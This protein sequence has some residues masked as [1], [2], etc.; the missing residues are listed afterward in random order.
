M[1]VWSWRE[2]P[3]ALAIRGDEE[4]E[5]GEEEEDTRLCACGGARLTRPPLAISAAAALRTG[6][7]AAPSRL[8]PVEP[9]DV[10]GRSA[11][12]VRRCDDDSAAD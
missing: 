11:V 2:S 3:R 5:T 9:E 4:G 6:S 12:P 1:G 7:V 10:V 8:P